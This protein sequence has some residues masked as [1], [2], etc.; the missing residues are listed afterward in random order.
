MFSDLVAATNMF[1][2]YRNSEGPGTTF[3]RAKAQAQ[4]TS[5]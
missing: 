4:A 2:I 1:E 3:I 5:S